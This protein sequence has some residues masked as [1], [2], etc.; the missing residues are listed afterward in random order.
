MRRG[1]ISRSTRSM[2]SMDGD[3]VRSARRDRRLPR[4]PR[5]VH[6]RCRRADRGGPA[7]RLPLLPLLGEPRRRAV[8][9]GRARRLPA[10]AGTARHGS[11]PSGSGPRSSACWRCR[12]SRRRSGRCGGRDPVARAARRMRAAPDL[13]APGPPAGCRGAAGDD[14]RRDAAQS[15]SRP[16]WRLSNDE[17]RP[18]RRSSSSAD[19]LSRASSSTKRPTAIRRRWPTG[20]EVAAVLADWT[21]AG[22][23]AV[24]DE[25]QS[26]EVPRFP[27]SGND[28]NERRLQAGQGHRGRARP[29]RAALDRERFRTRPR[30]AARSGDATALVARLVR[31][32]R[33]VAT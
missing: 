26:L 8:R 13:R 23:S 29:A 21:D 27:L 18:P 28:L 19:L 3:A 9:S 14:H 25:L 6:R 1:A 10:A 4:G 16:M 24:I 12:G 7:A 22:K 32:P 15:S 33:A 31:S 17:Y 2:P 5:A 11:R 20:S 30:R